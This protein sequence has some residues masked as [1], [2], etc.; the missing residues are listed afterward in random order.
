MTWHQ[1]HGFYKCHI[2][3][4]VVAISAENYHFISLGYPQRMMQ[5]SSSEPQRIDETPE[6]IKEQNIEA[7]NIVL[8]SDTDLSDDFVSDLTDPST[9]SDVSDQTLAFHHGASY[10]PQKIRAGILFPIHLGTQPGRPTSHEE[11]FA[12]EIDFPFA[13]SSYQPKYSLTGFNISTHIGESS[14]ASVDVRAGSPTETG[15][16]NSKSPITSEESFISRTQSP[17]K[18]HG[19]NSRIAIAGTEPKTSSRKVR[20]PIYSAREISEGPSFIKAL[21]QA[22]TPWEK[23]EQLYAAEFGVA[24]TQTGVLQRFNLNDMK[25]GDFEPAAFKKP[26][27]KVK[28]RVRDFSASLTPFSPHRPVLS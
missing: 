8:H 27:R 3:G 28:S 5:S 26:A 13:S 22:G 25:S 14:E 20:Q 17:T 16:S 19:A 18:N 24:R 7:Q 21:I 6:P 11:D 12:C 4:K 1:D 15:S 23:Q 10:A 2:Q 9:G